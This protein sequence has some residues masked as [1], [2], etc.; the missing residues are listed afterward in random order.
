MEFELTDEQEKLVSIVKKWYRDYYAGLHIGPHPH[1]FCYSGKPGCGKTTV[2]SKIISELNIENE[3]VATA[4]V[5][6]AV[7]RLQE[8]GLRA[9]TLHSLMYDV[10]F[11]SEPSTDSPKSKKLKVVFELKKELPKY[12]KLIIVDE[13]K[14][15]NDQMVEQLSTFGK[16]ILI[17]GDKNQLP[18]VYGKSTIMDNPDFTLTKIMRQKEDDPIVVLCNMILQGLPL[19]V[20]DYGKS[21]VVKYYELDKSFLTDFDQTI[22]ST[23]RNRDMINNFVRSGLL[24][25]PDN[26]PRIGDKVIC[27]QNNW[28]LDILGFN[29][30]NGMGG[31]I[32]DIDRSSLRRGCYT[33]DF[34][35]EIFNSSKFL[36]YDEDDLIFHN[37]EIDSKY[38]RGDYNERKLTGFTQYEKFEY[39]YA[40]TCYTA[41]GSEWKRGLYIHNFF[42]NADLT[43]ATA[44]TAISRFKESVTVVMQSGKGNL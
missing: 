17:M 9:Q 20:G 40:V 18:P 8:T 13:G 22:C 11:I 5:G 24:G 30:T 14:M 2:V 29:L 41:Q 39:A 3:Y 6:K 35:P 27:R 44:Y 19:M 23:N 28:A 36:E 37:L 10:K 1:Y 4:F 16:P 25:I 43:K 21:K 15:V 38:I 26:N 34:K 42:V 32:I 31:T 12:I 33:I 7:M